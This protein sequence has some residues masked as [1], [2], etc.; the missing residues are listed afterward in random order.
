MHHAFWQRV[1]AGAAPAAALF[2]AKGEYAKAI[3]HGQT[4]PSST[5]IE[6]KIWRQYTCLGLG[7]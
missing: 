4:K 1:L 5:A 3:P 2:D 6:F 7:W